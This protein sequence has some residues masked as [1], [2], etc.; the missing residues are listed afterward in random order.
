MC[1][2]SWRLDVCNPIAGPTSGFRTPWRGA[3]DPGSGRS[4]RPGFSS[5][6]RVRRLFIFLVYLSH[7][8]CAS[9]HHPT[10]RRGMC[11]PCCLYASDADY[12]LQSDTVSKTG[13][14]GS[15]TPIHDHPLTVAWNALLAGCKLWVAMPPDV[16]PAYLLLDTD[17]DFD[18]SALQVR[19]HN[20]TP[21]S[22]SPSSSSPSSSS[23]IPK[24]NQQNTNLSGPHSPRSLI[25]A[26]AHV[27]L[28]RV[29]ALSP[30]VLALGGQPAPGIGQD[31]S[32]APRRGRL[33]PG[34]APST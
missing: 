33:S 22:P 27:S 9:Q 19:P 3:R 28:S 24:K 6:P 7:A 26:F 12:S 5:A 21:S 14:S 29:R 4:H 1:A 32:P 8:F 13:A 2:H 20:S 16:D 18:L 17:D 11:L 31:Y 30:V 15:G 25:L 23:F 34:V 10:R